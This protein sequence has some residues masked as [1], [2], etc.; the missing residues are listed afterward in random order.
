MRHLSQRMVPGPEAMPGKKALDILNKCLRRVW[1][2]LSKLKLQGC[3]W[4]LMWRC[5]SMHKTVSLV[6]S[7]SRSQNHTGISICV[8]A[9]RSTE[10]LPKLLTVMDFGP[11]DGRTEG[12]LLLPPW[13]AWFLP[14]YLALL[15]GGCYLSHGSALRW[16]GMHLRSEWVCSAGWQLILE[17]EW[18]GSKPELT[19]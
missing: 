4:N 8:R 10:K 19:L 17:G 15:P 18:R 3:R 5:P 14:C 1:Q 12:F 16:S 11:R 6:P 13:G 7:T 2:N 9:H